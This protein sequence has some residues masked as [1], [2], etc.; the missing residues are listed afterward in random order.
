MRS[1]FVAALFAH[2]LAHLVGFLAYTRLWTIRPSAYRSRL[3]RDRL[4]I[5]D[6][7]ERALGVVWLLLA[8]GFFVVGSGVGLGRTWWPES[9]VGVTLASLVM[10]LVG[11]PASWI[12]ALVDV[13]ILLALLFRG[14]VG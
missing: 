4:R 12:G 6:P 13:G 8:L 7:M 10:C 9:A 11:L 2:G 5:P 1:L 14:S 3:L